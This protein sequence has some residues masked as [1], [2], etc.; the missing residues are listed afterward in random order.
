MGDC[1]A[2]KSCDDCIKAGGD[3]ECD[4]VHYHKGNKPVREIGYVIRYKPYTY[5]ENCEG[6]IYHCHFNTIDEFF[7]DE[8][9]F[10]ARVTELTGGYFVDLD[11]GVYDGV[12]IDEMYWCELHRI[13]SR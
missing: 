12:D 10:N 5:E 2:N 1:M 8:V 13:T 7:T 9:E 11:G 4:H 6:E 3:W